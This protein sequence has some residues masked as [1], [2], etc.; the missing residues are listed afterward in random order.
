MK[1]QVERPKD[2]KSFMNQDNAKELDSMMDEEESE[3]II[4]NFPHLK[5]SH[6]SKAFNPKVNKTGIVSPTDN[7]SSPMTQK[8]EAKR[9]HFTKLKPSSLKSRF[10]EA[11]KSED[12]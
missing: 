6:L 12:E 4:S 11:A 2:L 5:K 7:L 9:N 8:I 1:D 3:P 10:A